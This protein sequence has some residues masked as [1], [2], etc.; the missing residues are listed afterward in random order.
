MPPQANVPLRTANV[1]SNLAVTGGAVIDPDPAELG[2]RSIPTRHHPVDF[3]SSRSAVITASLGGKPVVVHNDG[4][5]LGRNGCEEAR[6]APEG[7]TRLT[8]ILPESGGETRSRFYLVG[9]S[10]GLATLT[11]VS[12]GDLLNVY[13]FTVFPP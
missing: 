3:V 7:D 1:A 5:L 12:E 8:V 2:I 4:E 10:P 13:Q 6:F 11:I 9:C